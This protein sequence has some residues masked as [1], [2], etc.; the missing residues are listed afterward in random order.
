MKVISVF[1]CVLALAGCSNSNYH[2][3]QNSRNGLK[4]SEQ[5]L[6]GNAITNSKCDVDVIVSN[7]EKKVQES[8]SEDSKD[9]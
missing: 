2:I 1:V 4:C 3:E 6:R 9:K 8:L 7:D 5:D